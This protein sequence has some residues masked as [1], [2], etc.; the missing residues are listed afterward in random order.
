L[1]IALLAADM[2][3]PRDGDFVAY[4]D[5]LQSE[6]AER[7][8]LHHINVNLAAPSPTTSSKASSHFFESTPATRPQPVD[9][10]AQPTVPAGVRP[11]IDASVVRAL[12]AA[13]IGLAFLVGWFG[14]SGALSFLIGVALLAYALPRLLA[15]FRMIAH[16]PSGKAVIGQVFRQKGSKR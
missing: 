16:Q 13:V 12:V 4:I 6:S 15:A 3:E 11:D 7:L 14:R 2:Q 1:R 5:K 10:P 8:A 9:A